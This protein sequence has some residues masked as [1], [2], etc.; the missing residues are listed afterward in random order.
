[1]WTYYIFKKTLKLPQEQTFSYKVKSHGD[2]VHSIENIAKDTV[3]T[4]IVGGNDLVL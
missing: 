4:M 2:L 1:M 3:I